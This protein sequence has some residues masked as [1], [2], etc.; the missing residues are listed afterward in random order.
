MRCQSL[1]S[2][3][4]PNGLINET[5]T[6]IRYMF[7]DCTSLTELDLTEQDLSNV[8]NYDNFVPNVS[9]LTIKYN[10]NRINNDIISA[11][12][13]VNWVAVS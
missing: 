8:T 5:T 1:Q 10:L 3:D 6:N 2:V 9:T 11:F 13:N 7:Y 4:F 12:S